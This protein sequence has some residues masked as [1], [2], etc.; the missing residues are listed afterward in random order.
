MIRRTAVL[1]LP[2]PAAEQGG[3][4]ETPERATENRTPKDYR[5]VVE[6]GLGLGRVSRW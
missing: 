6:R 4:L 1:R 5:I 2:L 3:V